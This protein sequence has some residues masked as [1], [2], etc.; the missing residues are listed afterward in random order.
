VVCGRGEEGGGAF[1]GGA[2]EEKKRLLFCA[3][4]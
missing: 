3:N 2:G 1:L 4:Y